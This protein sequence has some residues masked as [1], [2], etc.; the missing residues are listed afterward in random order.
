MEKSALRNYI[1]QEIQEILSE[2][3]IEEGTWSKGTPEQI[4]NF[5]KDINK[6]QTH[7]Y[8]IVGDD[9][10]FNGLD[11]AVRRAQQMVKT[12]DEATEEEV[13]NQKDLNKE[14][15]T[16]A[17]IKKDMELKEFEGPMITGENELVKAII[18]MGK[19]S[20]PF[21]K[22]LEKLLQDIGSGAGHALRSEAEE[23]DDEFDVVDKEPTKK[24][25]KGDSVAVRGRKLQETITQMKALAKKYKEAEGQEKEKIKE[26]LKT[27]TKIK[28][29]LESSL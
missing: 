2:D 7:Y 12:V 25:L 17:K 5:I 23:E 8:D 4:Q 21:L 19:K 15:E 1:K 16:T 27:L 6:I 9:E 28:K 20:K 3:S 10:V 14:L 29:E 24:D 26:R 18:K 13:K 11:A 22:K